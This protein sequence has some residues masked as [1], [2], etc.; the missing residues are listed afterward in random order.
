VGSGDR[1]KAAL[2][3]LASLKSGNYFS[4][5]PTNP[6]FGFENNITVR[7]LPASVGLFNTTDSALCTLRAQS[8]VAF[9]VSS[10]REM[11]AL[12]D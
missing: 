2:L 12:P 9:V 8:L 5:W 10:T 7:R 4:L 1:C 11:V 6:S 3:P